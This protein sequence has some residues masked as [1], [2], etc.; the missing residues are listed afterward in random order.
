[1]GVLVHIFGNPIYSWPNSTLISDV[2]AIRAAEWMRKS[3]GFCHC[4]V[5]SSAIPSLDLRIG[6]GKIESMQEWEACV[7]TKMSSKR[8]HKDCSHISGY[9]FCLFIFFCYFFLSFGRVVPTIFSE[10]LL[11]PPCTSLYNLV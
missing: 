6:L 3:D 5:F 9:I 10:C 11:G 1:M 2:G 4:A 8:V 7:E